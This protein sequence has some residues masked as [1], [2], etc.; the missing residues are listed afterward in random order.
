LSCGVARPSDFDEHLRGLDYY[1][2][3]SETI[4]PIGARLEQQMHRVLGAEWCQRWFSFAA[5]SGR[6]RQVNIL[7]ILRLWTYAKSLDLVNWGKM[8]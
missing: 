4:A 8:R 5:V 6:S 2:R 3:I 1:D 7:E